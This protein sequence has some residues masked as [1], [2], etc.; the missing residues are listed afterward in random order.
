MQRTAIV[1]MRR[2]AEALVSALDAF[3]ARLPAVSPLRSA[4]VCGLGVLLAFAPSASGSY[5]RSA[6]QNGASGALAASNGA[7]EILATWQ[8]A[9]GTE[10]GF[11][12]GSGAMA[13][14]GSTKA[15]FANTSTVSAPGQLSLLT[16]A[17][18]VPGARPPERFPRRRS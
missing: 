2:T 5:G 16:G 13:A 15:G 7:G 9:Q 14:I 3:A 8:Q 11:C 1:P 6:C 17:F 10:G 18:I 4:L 12:L